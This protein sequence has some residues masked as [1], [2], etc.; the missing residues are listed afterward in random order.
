M[1]HIVSSWAV[2]AFFFFNLVISF[3]GHEDEAYYLIYLLEFFVAILFF[4]T[5]FNG[6][7]NRLFLTRFRLD[8]YLS[9]WLARCRESSKTI[10]IAD[11]A[12]EKGR[13][14]YCFT[15]G[16]FVIVLTTLLSS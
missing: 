12:N 1:L 15:Y 3:D 11:Y 14:F 13:E 6:G 10:L 7:N 5:I 8:I 16:G 4:S 2:L 9:D